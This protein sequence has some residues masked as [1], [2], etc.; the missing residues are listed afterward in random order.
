MQNKEHHI[1]CNYSIGDPKDCKLCQRLNRE[2]P[3]KGRT[4]AEMLEDY[5][6]D[7]KTRS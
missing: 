4:P 6:P 7:V 5:F 1:W 3:E 2:C